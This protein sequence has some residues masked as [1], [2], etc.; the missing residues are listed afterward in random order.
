MK[1]IKSF[2][3]LLLSVSVTAQAGVYSSSVY[4]NGYQYLDTTGIPNN[5]IL[6]GNLNGWAS[7]QTLTGFG[8]T[9][10]VDVSLKLN[11]SGGYNGDLYAYLSYGNVLVPLLNRV[12]V[13]ASG[14]E[15]A[16]GYGDQGFN[17]TFTSS[18]SDI[19]TYRP[20]GT[21]VGG[22][23]TGTWAADGRNIDPLSSPSAFDSA[24]RT[25]LALYNGMTTINGA[26]TL[27]I[28]DVSPGGGNETV[29][30]W[31]LDITAVPEPIN[32]ALGTFGVALALFGVCRTE[33]VRRFF[34]KSVGA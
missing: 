29:N 28:A 20:S 21:I 13:G 17:V 30:S 27:F 16:Y 26:W 32:V 25:S 19:H 9:S 8:A 6:D 33:A 4:V 10:I 23:L 22:Q 7:A 12:G 3:V 31:E 15:T 24:T 2:A 1:L 18:G 11:V 5:T 14:N 34:R